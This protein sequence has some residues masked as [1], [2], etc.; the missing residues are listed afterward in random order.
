M[1]SLATAEFW[2]QFAGLPAEV[3]QNAR[4]AY[5]LWVRN[6]QHNSL[7]FKKVGRLWSVRI[8]RGYRALGLFKDDTIHWFW[9]GPHDEYERILMK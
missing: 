4:K 9:I 3:Q 6:P 8:S 1:K 7:R 5:R 2:R